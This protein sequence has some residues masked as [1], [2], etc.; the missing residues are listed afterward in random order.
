MSTDKVIPWRFL[1]DEAVDSTDQDSF[2]THSTYAKLLLE[3]ARTAATPFSI[4]LY[5]SWGTG[6]TSVAKMLQSLAAK[7]KGIAVV[8]LDVWKYSSD[9]LKRWILLETSRQLEKQEILVAYKYEDR[10]LQS[11]LEFEEQ[12]EDENK[13]TVDYRLLTRFVIVIVAFLAILVLASLYLP[14]SLK[15]N[16]ALNGLIAVLVSAG[17]T[18]VA[19][20]SISIEFLKSVSG[21]IFRR[22]IRQVTAKP[23]FSSEK[24]GEIFQHLVKT[25]TSNSVSRILFVFD[26]LDRCSEEVAVEAIGVI[27]T[28]LDEPNCV[29]LIP[30]DENA[31]VRHISRAYAPAEGGAEGCQDN[32]REFLNKFFQATIRLPVASSFDIE[33]YLDEQ[34]AVV[35][36]T[37]LPVE[38]RDVVVLGYLGL[39][40]RQIKRMINDLIVYRS[41]AV[42]SE[43]DGLVGEKDLTGDLPLL[44]KMAVISE[45]WPDLLNKMGDD[46]D[47]WTDLAEKLGPGASTSPSEVGLAEFLSATKHVSPNSDARSFV[48]LKRFDFERDKPLSKSVEDYL[49]KGDRAKYEDLIK[50]E[51]EPARLDIIV[52]MTLALCRQWRDNEREV[53]LKNAAPLLMRAALLLPDKRELR[54]LALNVLEFLAGKLPPEQLEEIVNVADVLDL[55][56]S[57]ATQEKKVVLSKLVAL[58]SPQFEAT[59][60]RMALWRLVLGHQEQLTAQQKSRVAD[61]IRERYS[62]S[63]VTGETA[64]EETLRL[65]GVSLTRPKDFYWCVGSSLLSGIISNTEFSGTPLDVTRVDTLVAYQHRLDHTTRGQ[66]ALKLSLGYEQPG[67]QTYDENAEGVTAALE[68]FEPSIF[69]PAELEPLG[70]ILLKQVTQSKVGVKPS[71]LRP[72][73]HIYSV[74]PESLRTSTDE[75]LAKFVGAPTEPSVLLGFLTSMD[76]RLGLWLLS[77]AAVR[78]ALRSQGGYLEKWGK[79]QSQKQ[80]KEYLSYL[81]AAGLLAAP[82][83]FDES[84]VS[85]LKL[86][87]ETV[88]RAAAEE[89]ANL[90]DLRAKLLTFCGRYVVAPQPDNSEL[91]EAA[92]GAVTSDLRLLDAQIAAALARAAMG[93][94][95]SVDGKESEV[96]GYYKDFRVW[97]KEISDES[98]GALLREVAAAFLHDRKD[99]WL[100]ILQLLAEDVGDSEFQRKDGKLVKELF[101]YAFRAAEE[102]PDGGAEPLLRLLT[103]L[104]NEYATEYLD[105]GVETLIAYEADRKPLE[106]MEPFLRMI[107]KSSGRLAPDDLGRVVKFCK[108]M[109]G[110]SNSREEH[111]RA[112]GFIANL[113]R[114]D[115]TD[116]L[117]SELE[118]VAASQDEEL[119]AAAKT[120]LG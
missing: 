49:R 39:T 51:R 19:L 117:R 10:T 93:L 11:H 34:L 83:V 5:S 21:L 72:M 111:A 95:I 3:I 106:R 26:N 42:Q 30:C 84:E 37:D 40:P 80:R 9:P 65:L 120:L 36:M 85:D 67:T 18:S 88:Q 116:A 74:L 62:S 22:T 31:L 101:D 16:G 69:E 110:P 68:R 109:L 82:E 48:F 46:P 7:E 44:T 71:W 29:Y 118:Q 92:S 4:A 113:K 38:A 20:V 53:F 43:R 98:Q 75:F 112:L 27:K 107:E 47:L 90:E 6:K 102:E 14:G 100:R 91:Y 55:D 24:F 104:P 73:V 52:R 28:Y 105:R 115:L 17:L 64:E 8:Y 59:E 41:L 78:E 2:G 23:A 57:A 94:M 60:S 56:P 12:V 66:L 81:D 35:G 87:V 25:A 45:K 13:V 79:S 32:A 15:S 108:R 77:I 99:H 114:G 63:K 50:Q 96:E 76:S 119:A 58:F 70:T 103:H 1:S 33:K 89:G 61:S 97:K 54:M 86:Y